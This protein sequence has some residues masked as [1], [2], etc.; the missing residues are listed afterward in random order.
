MYVHIG[1]KSEVDQKCLKD[2][3]F[4]LNIIIFYEK[5]TSIKNV[6]INILQYN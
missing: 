3:G 4:K 2:R 1:E 6:F 5:L